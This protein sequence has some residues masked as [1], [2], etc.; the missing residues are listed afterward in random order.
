MKVII[1]S[2]V[3][4]TIFLWWFFLW[5]KSLEIWEWSF[6]WKLNIWYLSWSFN[7]ENDQFE[8]DKNLSRQEISDLCSKYVISWDPSELTKHVQGSIVTLIDNAKN[9]F[10][11][12]GNSIYTLYYKDTKDRINFLKWNFKKMD[13]SS[14]WYATVSD[15]INW[16]NLCESY[17]KKQQCMNQLEVLQSIINNQTISKKDLTLENSIKITLYSLQNNLSKDAY[18]K[19]IQ[20]LSLNYCLVK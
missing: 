2:I 10:P 13:P 14:M 8:K 19:L 7:K 18:L 15:I 12:E 20:E 4:F 16:T 5:K 17:P 9:A 6:S 3:F 1:I 11:I